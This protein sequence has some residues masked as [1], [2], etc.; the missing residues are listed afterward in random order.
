MRRV[1]TTV[2]L[3]GLLRSHFPTTASPAAAARISA[4]ASYLQRCYTSSRTTS[5]A[6]VTS[7]S[8]QAALRAL[9]DAKSARLVELHAVQQECRHEARRHPDRYMFAAFAFLLVQAVVLFDWTYIH[10]DWNLVEP[11]TYL[12][13]Y[14]GTW[15]ALA[16]YG[17]MQEEFG[18]DSLRE[19][20]EVRKLNSLY[21]AKGV[22]V[23]EVDRLEDEVERLKRMVS[24]AVSS[25]P[26]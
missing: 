6:D 14:A 11:I 22:D 7:A 5:S 13:G 16:W 2:G 12:I 24:D 10:F 25:T 4:A 1:A 18:F 9:L 19:M 3:D 8:S 17:N 26:Q 23:A 15:I 20:I 21:A